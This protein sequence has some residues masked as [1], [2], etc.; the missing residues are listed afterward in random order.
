MD[1]IIYIVA[2]P[3]FFVSFAGYLYANWKLRKETRADL[4][5]YYWEVEDRH[6][7]LAK[8]GKWSRIT[9]VAAAVSALAIFIAAAV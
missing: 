7:A 6:P 9:F 3:L 1:T 8:Y 2:G 4:D 5:D